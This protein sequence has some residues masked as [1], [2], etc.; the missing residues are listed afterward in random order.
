MER[1]RGWRGALPACLPERLNIDDNPQQP[2][3]SHDKPRQ[4][5][6]TTGGGKFSTPGGWSGGGG[7]SYPAYN[8]RYENRK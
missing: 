7:G 5:P 8:A 4:A 6:E 3:T 2:T 1:W